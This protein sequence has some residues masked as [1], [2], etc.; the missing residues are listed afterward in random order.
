MKDDHMTASSI[1]GN[2]ASSY[3]PQGAHINNRSKQYQSLVL[4]IKHHFK[5][6]F[7]YWNYYITFVWFNYRGFW[8]AAEN[9]LKQRIQVEFITPYKI[10]AIQTQGR[11]DGGPQWLKSYKIS[12]SSNMVEWKTYTHKSGKDKVICTVLILF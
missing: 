3:G 5:I 8:C 11:S 6:E 7:V 1:W 12:Y 2:Q 10:T 4:N 9:N